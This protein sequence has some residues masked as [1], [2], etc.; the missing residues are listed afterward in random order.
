M[1]Y[2]F[3]FIEYINENDILNWGLLIFAIGYLIYLHSKKKNLKNI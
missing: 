1:E 2:I 3:K